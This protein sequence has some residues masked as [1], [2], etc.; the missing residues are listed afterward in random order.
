MPPRRMLNE[1]AAQFS[2]LP[3]KVKVVFDAGNGTAG[4]M[5]HRILERLNVEPVE[6][7]FDMDGRFPNHHPD[8]TVVS[9]LKH[10]QDAVP[11]TRQNSASPL[12]ATRTALAR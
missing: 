11:K 4:P 9:N 12:T 7:F 10:L 5:I 6:L 3:R 1:V 8:P 2:A